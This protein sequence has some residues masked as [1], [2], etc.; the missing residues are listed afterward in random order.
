ML[1]AASGRWVVIKLGARGCLALGPSGAEL[2]VDAPTV[3]VV[4]TTGAGDSFNAGLAAS[5]ANGRDWPDALRA[6]TELAS[7]II[8]RP[9][10]G[11][12]S[13]PAS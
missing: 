13:L 6:A 2:S 7:S 8:S 9:S 4:D 3:T 5:L 1:Q 12:Y 10:V 11:R